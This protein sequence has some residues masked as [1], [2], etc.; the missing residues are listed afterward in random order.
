VTIA[1][2]AAA[3]VLGSRRAGRAAGRGAA[4]CG[5]ALALVY[6]RVRPEPAKPHEVVPCVPLEL[7]REHVA[8]LLAIGEVVPLAELTY[9]RAS[10]RP[11]FA[12]TFDDDYSTHFSQVLPV[13]MELGVPATFF[14]SGRSLHGKGAYWWEVLEALLH[15]DGVAKVARYLNVASVAP[16]GIAQA[17]EADIAR[18]LHLEAIG[19]DVADQLT[20]NE[21]AAMA[22]AGATIGFHTV[23]HRALPALGALDRQR[24]LTTGLMD[25]AELTGQRATLFAYPHGKVDGSSARDVRAAG[26]DAA[27]TGAD[28]PL[29]RG[30]DRWR[31]GRWEPGA[32]NPADLR[33][34]AL[35]RL[36]RPITTHA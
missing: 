16:H 18:Q 20:P 36:I 14:L 30:N 3:A 23:E 12:L 28:A 5:R 17:C 27:W 35:G 25:L 8:V 26:F 10:R 21:I 22:M 9:S 19:G 11:R 1:R 6:H 13:L 31:L 32:I 7:F 29:S 4:G 33:V 34:R 2:R 15:V 24:A